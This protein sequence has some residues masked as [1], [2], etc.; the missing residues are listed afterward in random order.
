LG[1]RSKWKR[2]LTLSYGLRYLRET[3]RS[4]SEYPPIPQLNALMPGLGNRVREP[5]LNFAPQ[6]GFAWDPTGKGE[7]S[8][9]GGIGLFYE[10]VLA[11]VVPFD[12][13]YR[14]P[15]AQGQCLP[16]VSDLCPCLSH[17][18]P[19]SQ[20]SVAQ[21][22][23]ARLPSELWAVRLPHSGNNTRLIPRSI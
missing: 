18:A 21:R 19:S 13:L 17:G 15:C 3:G 1:A 9:R 4:D 8:A 12:A 7:T 11:S 14:V 20:G 5:N 6:L 2:N 23:G 10:N 22:M 16:P